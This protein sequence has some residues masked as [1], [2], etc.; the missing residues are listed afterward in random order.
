M[1]ELLTFD[2]WAVW[3]GCSEGRGME[4]ITDQCQA[5]RRGVRTRT[6]EYLEWTFLLSF[7]LL[8]LVMS[9]F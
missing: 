1:G 5:G 9:C 3:A 8:Y 7:I 2:G 4:W 6:L